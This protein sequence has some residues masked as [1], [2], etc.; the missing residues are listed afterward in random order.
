MKDGTLDI[1][2]KILSKLDIVLAAAH[3]NFKMP[4]QDTTKR[5]C[6][7]M[8]NPNVD[9]L[10][11]PTGR[12]IQKR[13]GYQIDFDEILTCAKRTGTI[14]EINSYPARL[15]L[16]DAHIK[17]AVQAE[18]KLSLGTDS[19]AKNQLSNMEFGVSQARRG[20]AEKKDII[21]AMGYGDLTEFLK[22]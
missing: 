17:K 8:E 6:R 16:N 22:K 20:W 7:A 14:L 19:H 5:I 2:D 13:E 4:R 9:I 18:V 3:S 15:D 11:H 21:N 12:V 10:A 1:S